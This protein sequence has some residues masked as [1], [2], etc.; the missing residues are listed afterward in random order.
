[1]R[2]YLYLI[3]SL[4]FFSLCSCSNDDGKGDGQTTADAVLEQKFLGTSWKF[5]KHIVVRNGQKIDYASEELNTI[6][7]FSGEIYG[8]YNGATMTAA[9][10]IFLNG[11]KAGWWYVSDGN[12][13][14][15]FNLGAHENG[16][17]SAALGF[18]NYNENLIEHTSSSIIYSDE[19]GYIWYYKACPTPNLDN[20]GST[21]GTSYEKPD[22]YYYDC[23][24]GYT[25]LKVQFKI[26]NKGKTNVTSAKGYCGGK[27]VSG[28]IGSSIITFNFTNLKKGTKYQVYCTATGKGGTGTSDKVTLTTLN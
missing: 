21:P 28:N 14:V 4:F 13:R 9:N 5:V 20:S 6:V 11:E 12:L 26:G 22:V 27:T 7:T 16:R 18:N 19:R 24:P 1:M 3:V 25:T 10:A 15:Q 2:K 8:S 23:T 17:W